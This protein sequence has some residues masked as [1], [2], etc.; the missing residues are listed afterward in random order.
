MRH[1]GSVV[2]TLVQGIMQTIVRV[3]KIAHEAQNQNKHQ[4]AL[5]RPTC[6]SANKV[7][8]KLVTKLF[9]LLVICNFGKNHDPSGNFKGNYTPLKRCAET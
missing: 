2:H 7:S 9:A 4:A 1:L 8:T 3:R 6:M 5:V